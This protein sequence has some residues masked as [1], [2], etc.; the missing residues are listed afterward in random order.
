MIGE[1]SELLSSKPLDS[2]CVIIGEFAVCYIDRI[3]ISS[4]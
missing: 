2:L 3:G 4:M 1:E